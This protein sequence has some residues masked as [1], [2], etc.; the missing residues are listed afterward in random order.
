MI[1]RAKPPKRIGDR[2]QPY[3]TPRLSPNSTASSNANRYESGKSVPIAVR[4]RRSR[5]AAQRQRANSM[6]WVMLSKRTAIILFLTLCGSSFGWASTRVGHTKPK[7]LLSYSSEVILSQL[8]PV[9]EEPKAPQRAEFLSQASPKTP[10]SL[11]KALL[12]QS[13]VLDDNAIAPRRAEFLA[14]ASPQV[15]RQGTQISLNGRTFGV[16]WQQ[17]QVGTSVRIGISDIGLMQSLGVELL[18]TKDVTRQ[19]VRWFSS[20]QSTPLV[21]ASQLM[22]SY[23]YLDITD[24]AKVAGWQLQVE[25][26]VAASGDRLRISSTPAQVKAIRQARQPW[27]SRIVVDLDRPIPWQVSDNRTAGVITL[28]ASANSSLIERFNA[29]PP[30]QRQD[31]EDAAPVSVRAEGE[32]AVIRV[33]QGQKQT[34][35]RV[36]IPTGK[37]LQVYSLPNPNRLVIDL[38]PDAL[39]EKE[40][41]WA[42]GIRWHQKYVTLK[43]SRFPVVWLEVDPRTSGASF[44]PIWSNPAT[45]I[46]TAPLIQT[47]QMWQA[48]AAINAG[49]FNRNNQLPL[50]AVR[51]D[52]RWFSGPILNRGAI[53]WN[54]SGQFK[55]GRLTLQETLV[56]SAGSRLPILLLNTGYV[57]TG[58]ARYTP[59]WGSTYTPLIDN[60]VLFV[61]QNDQV[62][63]QLPGGTAGQQSF[64]IP[65]DGYLITLRGSNPA[66]GSLSVGTQVSLESLTTPGDFGSYPHILGAGPLL[67]QNRQIVLNAKAE[68]FSDA[69]TKQSAIRSC[70]GTTAAGT[71]M[72]AAIH[73]RTGGLGPTLAETAQLMQLLGAA[74][75]LNFD[76]GSSTGLYLGG[77]LLDRSPST[78]ARVHNGLGIFR[79]P[80]P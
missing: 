30:P 20:P 64:P 37:R 76:G 69:F 60:E 11:T 9:V 52:E 55:F 71:L 66:S 46:G 4:C 36:D 21:L 27:G 35:L 75:A 48:F 72:I 56:T 26:A 80:S 63:S 61:V 44:R 17:W 2:I 54:D 7:P 1:K 45:Q 33:E 62:V 65:P 79:S 32:D 74:N 43:G 24:L 29:P 41:S 18:S 25:G 3:T 42:P 31:A 50:G 15:I 39:V 5:R 49:F 13:Q 58:F 70:I 57:Q 6:S 19:P 77:Q 59:E 12:T 23:R 53:A 38:R 51:R 67:V 47:A 28:E 73:N 40:I 10:S 14:Q 34:T 22:G 8:P 78:A 68:Q 16:A